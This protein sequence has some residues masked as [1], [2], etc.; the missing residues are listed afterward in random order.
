MSTANSLPRSTRQSVYTALP[1][2]AVFGPTPWLAFDPLDIDVRTRPSD[3]VPWQVPPVAWSAD[4]S[5]PRAGFVT[6]AFAAGLAAGTRVLVQGR[7]VHGRITDV[8]RGGAIVTAALERELDMQAA[9]LQEL[10]RDTDIVGDAFGAFDAEVASAAA[11]A[12][13]ARAYA[14]SPY[15]VPVA[16]GERSALHWS[17]V[18]HQFATEAEA[19][20]ASVGGIIHDFGLLSED[21]TSEEDW[22]TL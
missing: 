17:V 19:W 12:A 3:D 1:A 4:L 2:Q 20:A 9:T 10:R 13:T 16:E 7:R 14:T 6:V 8:T 22:G 15:E 21:V 5:S 11:S 18:S